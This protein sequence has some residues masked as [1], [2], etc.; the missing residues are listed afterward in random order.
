MKRSRNVSVFLLAALFLTGSSGLALT[1]E[2]QASPALSLQGP[3]AGIFI[4]EN[5]Y[6]YQFGW[7]GI[8]AFEGTIQATRHGSLRPWYH[9]RLEGRTRRWLDLIYRMRDTVDAYVDG[10][11][12]LPDLFYARHRAPRDNTNLVVRFDHDLRVAHARWVKNGKEKKREI[13]FHRPNDPVSALYLLESLRAPGDQA[14]FEVIN[15]KRNYRVGLHVT[16][17]E[18]LKVKAGTFDTLVIEPT[19]TRPDKPDYKPKFRHMT[20]WV[21]DGDTRI[22]V[23]LKSR[24]FI[25]S[26]SGELVKVTPRPHPA[27]VKS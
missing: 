19:L 17:R 23:K 12:Y 13:P 11:D 8:P 5:R 4:P 16:G 3:P 24:V 21:T 20:V 26:I 22:P 10:V 15:G 2:R 9:F 14:S 1:N 18:R 27:E 6:H 7:K 25:G